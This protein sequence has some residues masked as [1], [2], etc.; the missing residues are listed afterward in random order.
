VVIWCDGVVDALRILSVE[1]AALDAD[2][3]GLRKR[4]DDAARFLFP[5]LVVQVRAH[6]VALR[7]ETCGDATR[8]AKMAEMSELLEGLFVAIR[9]LNVALK[10]ME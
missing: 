7:E 5:G 10:R 8:S 1:L 2:W 6:L 4:I 9:H 3:L